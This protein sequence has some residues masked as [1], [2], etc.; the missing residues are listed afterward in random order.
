MLAISR[1]FHG[2]PIFVLLGFLLTACG[3]GGG[4]EQPSSLTYSDYQA[5]LSTLQ[6]TWSGVAA[7]DPSTLPISGSATFNGVLSLSVQTSGADLDMA[8][9]LTLTSNFATDTLTGN[10]TNFITAND[11]AMSGSLAITGGVLDRAANTNIAHTFS[12]AI[13]GTLGGAGDSY[14]IQGTLL[15]DFLGTGNLGTSG[16]VNG[17]ATS[18]FGVGYMFGDFLAQ[19]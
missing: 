4:D 2:H 9:A 13:D 3:G 18:S 1:V 12:A 14:L 10:A 15:G 11:A 6:T 19:Q 16:V 17:F 5:Q 7:T 8:G